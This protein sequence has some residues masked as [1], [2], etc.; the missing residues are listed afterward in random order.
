MCVGATGIQCKSLTVSHVLCIRYE[1]YT[2]VMFEGVTDMCV[3]ITDLCVTSDNGHS[4]EW[5]TSLTYR[6]LAGTIAPSKKGQPPNKMLVSI[7]R[8]IRCNV[9]I[10]TLERVV[11]ESSSRESR[12]E[13]LHSHLSHTSLS[14]LLFSSPLISCVQWNPCTLGHS[15]D[16][17]LFIEV[18]IIRMGPP[19]V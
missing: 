14:C 8:R 15:R 9:I 2:A 16:C 5:T 6:P 3:A 12:C 11:P 7:T 19:S 4:E 13:Y 17:P 10:C 18:S 1:L